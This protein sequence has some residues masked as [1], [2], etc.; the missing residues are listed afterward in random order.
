MDLIN[1]A[2]NNIDQDIEIEESRTNDHT[3][4]IMDEIPLDDNNNYEQEIEQTDF[5]YRIY[6]LSICSFVAISIGSLAFL[7]NQLSKK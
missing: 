2:L 5:C 1:D 6:I 3:D 4:I 7:A